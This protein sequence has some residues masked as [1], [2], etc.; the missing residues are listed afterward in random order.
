MNDWGCRWWHIT[1][2]GLWTV[3]VNSSQI[4]WIRHLGA[5]QAWPDLHGCTGVAWDVTG[6]GAGAFFSTAG[7][8][9]TAGA[10]FLWVAGIV[11]AV[12]VGYMCSAGGGNA[13]YA[14]EKQCLVRACSV[15]VV[16]L[17]T[18]LTALTVCS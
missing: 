1:E 15:A 6:I 14:T 12:D 9:G 5:M 3:Q 16:P 2:Q 10:W 17:G 8:A 7:M 4:S 11:G 18:V 13:G